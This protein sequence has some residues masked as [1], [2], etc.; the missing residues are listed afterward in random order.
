[1]A[2]AGCWL[3]SLGLS[4]IDWC[5]N[6]IKHCKSP[7]DALTHSQE[8]ASSWMKDQNV[9]ETIAVLGQPEEF[10]WCQH[11]G[12]VHVEKKVCSLIF[13]LISLRLWSNSKHSYPPDC[14]S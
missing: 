10:R 8:M 3:L 1:M 14:Y 6:Q 2:I 9:Q 12:T 4:G 11:R 7:L 5:T 13:H